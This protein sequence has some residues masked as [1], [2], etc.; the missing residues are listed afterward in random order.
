MSNLPEIF[1]ASETVD[2]AS[3]I[4][5]LSKL[6]QFLDNNKDHK[7]M[8]SLGSENNKVLAKFYFYDKKTMKSFTLT[9]DPN[10]IEGY[11]FTL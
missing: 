2:D 10:F 4:A 9:V 7:V 6:H 3:K 11:S 1:T 8:I 5:L